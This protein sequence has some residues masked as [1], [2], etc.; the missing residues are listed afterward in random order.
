[1]EKGEVGHTGILKSL[2]VIH[3]HVGGRLPT[4]GKRPALMAMVKEK[5]TIRLDGNGSQETEIRRKVST[6]VAVDEGMPA[7]RLDTAHNRC[8]S[9][10]RT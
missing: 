9:F 2:P 5:R 3:K 8:V 6:H 4:K 7:L 1:V 10:V